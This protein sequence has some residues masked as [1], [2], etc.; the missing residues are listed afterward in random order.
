MNPDTIKIETLKNNNI[1]FHSGNYR[2]VNHNLKLATTGFRTRRILIAYSDAIRFDN[3]SLELM[4][5]RYEA[6]RKNKNLS[7]I[8]LQ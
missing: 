7:K 5:E 2:Y 1:E 4:K 6:I 3:G 8:S